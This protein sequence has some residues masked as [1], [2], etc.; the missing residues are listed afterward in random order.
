[1]DPIEQQI[2]NLL[3]NNFGV[4]E[5]SLTGEDKLATDL[6]L[7]SLEIVEFALQ[8]EETFG[9]EVSDDALTASM[10]VGEVVESIRKLRG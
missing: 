1:M 5:D 10:T 3:I 4:D 9:V 8:L 7:D 6:D 2:R